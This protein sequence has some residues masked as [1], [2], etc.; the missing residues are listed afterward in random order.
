VRDGVRT[1]AGSRGTGVYGDGTAAARRRGRERRLLCRVA[2]GRTGN[3]APL[4][5]PKGGVPPRAWG[6]AIGARSWF[7]LVCSALGAVH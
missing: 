4:R 3:V 5:V 6:G 2:G 7:E 1:G